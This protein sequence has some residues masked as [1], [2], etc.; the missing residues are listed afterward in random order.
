[1]APARRS[2]PTTLRRW[3]DLAARTGQQLRASGRRGGGDI[4]EVVAREPVPTGG[5]PQCGCWTRGGMRCR[6]ETAA[7]PAL[8]TDTGTVP[9]DL[10]ERTAIALATGSEIGPTRLLNAAELERLRSLAA[11]HEYRDSR[12][13]IPS[14]SLR[15]AVRVEP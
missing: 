9:H 13:K 15:L 4:P 3:L 2:T 10:A 12:G 5:G 11:D 7:V 6:V 8:I 14:L 1:L